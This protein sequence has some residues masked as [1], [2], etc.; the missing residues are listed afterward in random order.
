MRT[1]GTAQP[2]HAAGT[3]AGATH[4]LRAS[5]PALEAAG[6]LAEGGVSAEAM[7]AGLRTTRSKALM[8]LL[9]VH[10]G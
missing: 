4:Q 3:P 2:C 10:D 1:T 9:A 6:V 7:A 5:R 8:L